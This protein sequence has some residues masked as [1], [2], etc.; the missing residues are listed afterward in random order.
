MGLYDLVAV[1]SPLGLISLLFSALFLV[2]ILKL[3]KSSIAMTTQCS[4]ELWQ[5]CSLFRSDV[6][7]RPFKQ[8][9]LILLLSLSHFH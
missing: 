4:R 6:P 8:I 5:L 9:F 2:I 3:W 7:S 1:F